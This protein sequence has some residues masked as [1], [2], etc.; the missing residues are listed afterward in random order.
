MQLHKLACSSLSLHA[1]LSSSEQ[2]TRISQCLFYLES[3]ESIGMGY[4]VNASLALIL[5]RNRLEGS[6]SKTGRHAGLGLAPAQLF[7]QGSEG[8]GEGLSLWSVARLTINRPTFHSPDRV[9]VAKIVFFCYYHP[10]FHSSYLLRMQLSNH[11]RFIK[12]TPI[13]RKGKGRRFHTCAD[14]R[15]ITGSSSLNWT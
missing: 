4:L 9:K 8:L 14:L 6:L 12:T 10:T 5:S 13:F 1:V 2:L 15:N 7:L 3:T 11:K